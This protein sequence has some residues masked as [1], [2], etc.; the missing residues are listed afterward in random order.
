[1]TLLALFDERK[2]A[3]H[4]AG[5]IIDA[6]EFDALHAATGLLDV[7]QR[8]AAS[9]VAQ[10]EALK[11]AQ[12]Q[13][14]YAQGLADGAAAIAQRL[15]AIDAGLAAASRQAEVDVLDLVRVVLERLA[16]ALPAGDLLA[17]LV[18]QAVAQQRHARRLVL[19]VHPDRVARIESE[20]DALRAAC[21]WLESL[22]VIGVP[23]LDLE[24]CVLES[25]FG[26]VDASWDVQRAG[27]ERALREAI[28]QEPAQ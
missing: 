11:Q 14:G 21:N 17:A 25:P 26:H 13:A 3:A 8:D 2:L 18:S 1:M 7:A 4:I 27:I 10:A 28:G 24:A 15:A 12:G 5:P 23:G 20:L 16:P 19:K 22:D 9:I 6:A